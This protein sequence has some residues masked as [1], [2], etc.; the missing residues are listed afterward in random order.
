M[1]TNLDTGFQRAAAA[2]GG[3]LLKPYA[4]YKQATAGNTAVDP[5]QRANSARTNVL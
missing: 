2:P 5:P 4:L 3:T 1:A